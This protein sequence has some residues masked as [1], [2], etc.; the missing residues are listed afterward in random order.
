MHRQR[1][2]RP[3]DGDKGLAEEHKSLPTRARTVSRRWPTDALGKGSPGPAG[4][5]GGQ[6]AGTR[7]PGR[8]KLDGREKW[9]E[10]VLVARPTRQNKAPKVK[11][12]VIG[13]FGSGKLVATCKDQ[14][15]WDSNLLNLPN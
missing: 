12:G 1:G 14:I 3:G 7:S 13:L 4:R 11:N 6:A 15:G 5:D 8:W 10:W 9:H 2:W